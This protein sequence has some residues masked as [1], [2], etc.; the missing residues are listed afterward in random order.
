[1]KTCKSCKR[2]E[3]GKCVE[4]G[5]PKGLNDPICEMYTP[6]MVP[7]TLSDMARLVHG[8]ERKNGKH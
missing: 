6:T 3:A 1:M 8:D 5:V 2:W 7:Q 4:M